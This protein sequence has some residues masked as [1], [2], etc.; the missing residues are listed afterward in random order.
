ME[1]TE[2]QIF[3]EFYEKFQPIQNHLVD[4]APEGGCMFETYGDELAFVLSQD[5]QNIW[6]IVEGENKMHYV[7]GYHLV[8]RIGYLVMKNPWTLE[9]KDVEIDTRGECEE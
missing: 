6:T 7:K 4:D 1:M 2:D 5:P 3:D 9:D 8:N